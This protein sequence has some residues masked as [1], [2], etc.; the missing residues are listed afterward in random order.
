ML[1]LCPCSQTME[2]KASVPL[3][4]TIARDC[5]NPKILE[6]NPDCFEVRALV[7]ACAQMNMCVF[8]GE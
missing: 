2:A 7:R 6:K 3:D 5:Q 1:P 4:G 8:V